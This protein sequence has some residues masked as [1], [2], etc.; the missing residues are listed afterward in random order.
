MSKLSPEEYAKRLEAVRY[1][2][3]TNALEGTKPSQLV[4]DLQA[5]WVE[6]EITIEEAIEAAVRHYRHPDLPEPR[7]D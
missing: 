5:R 7:Q 3:A 4:Q 2:R 1:A 6:G